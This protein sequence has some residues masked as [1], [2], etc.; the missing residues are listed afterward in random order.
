MTAILRIQQA[1]RFALLLTQPRRRP[2]GV[3]TMAAQ[4]STQTTRPGPMP[5]IP[6]LVVPPHLERFNGPAQEYIVRHNKPW[7]GIAVGALVFSPESRVLVI[8]RAKTDSLPEKWEIPSGVVSNDPARDA[9]IISAVAR[10]LWEEIGLL[11][12]A[13]TRL[14]TAPAVIGSP[15]SEA[16]LQ[17]EADGFVF[18]NSTRTKVFCRYVFEADVEA[19]VPGGQHIRLNPC[20]H[21]DFLWVSEEEIRDGI[22]GEEKLEIDF[23]SK[24]LQRLIS[25]GFRLRRDSCSLREN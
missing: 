19:L 3:S 2:R 10:E 16:Q 11:A 17:T 24:H 6:D 22:V 9:T 13:L 8:Q 14:V 5:A 12:R 4:P 18:S 15:E 7:D 21:Q 1:H 20:E 23:T 25:E